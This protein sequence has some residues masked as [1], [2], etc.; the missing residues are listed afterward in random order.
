MAELNLLRLQAK[1]RDNMETD[2]SEDEKSSTSSKRK[3]T[4]LPPQEY[5]KRVQVRSNPDNP[6]MDIDQAT[7]IGNVSNESTN[8]ITNNDVVNSNMVQSDN[9]NDSM[10]SEAEDSN[11]ALSQF[12]LNRQESIHTGSQPG[13][14]NA[15]GSN[16]GGASA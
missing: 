2:Q 14:E 8:H 1:Q 9:E 15:T 13:L 5:Q 4:N 7:T 16:T 12:P 3:R 6:S 11:N 10:Y